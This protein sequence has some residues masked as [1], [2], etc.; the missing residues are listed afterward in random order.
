M[1]LITPLYSRTNALLLEGLEIVA[2]DS[3]AKC[4]DGKPLSEFIPADGV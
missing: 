1:P 4:V 2:E 3:G